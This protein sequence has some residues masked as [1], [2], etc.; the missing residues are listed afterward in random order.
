MTKESKAEGLIMDLSRPELK[1]FKV[2]SSGE[3]NGDSKKICLLIGDH[4]EFLPVEPIFGST[5][6]ND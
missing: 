1:G 5:Q 4:W 6:E 3:V 2:L